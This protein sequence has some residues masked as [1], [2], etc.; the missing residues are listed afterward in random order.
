MS[1]G[2][3]KNLTLH[4]KPYENL[5]Q[6]K[7]LGDFPVGVLIEIMKQELDWDDILRIRV[8]IHLCFP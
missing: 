7:N 4:P 1:L 8:C 2:L 3:Q 5:N 6:M